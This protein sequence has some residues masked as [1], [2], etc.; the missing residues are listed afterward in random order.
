MFPILGIVFVTFLVI[1]VAIPVLPLHVHDGLGLGPFIV[2]LVAGSQFAASL[3]S[4]IWAGRQAD[5]R[6]P[7]YAVL[8]GL[9][10]S[11]IAGVIYLVS[12]RFA[13]APALSAAIL[14]V[15]RGVL[16]AGESL[17]ITG[18]Q[19]WGLAIAPAGTTGR[20]IAWVG[21]AMFAAFALGA[22][23]GSAIYSQFGF[24]SIAWATVLM[25]LATVFLAM[26]MGRI[27]PHAHVEQPP[28]RRVIGFVL[29]PGIGLALASIGFGAI[30]AF[31]SLLFSARGWPVWLAFSAYAIAFVLAR[32]ALGHLADRVGGARVAIAF[33]LVEAI[34][35]ALM[36]GAQWLPMALLGAALTGLGFS[37][38]YPALGIEA[39]RRTPAQSRGTAMGVYGAFLDLALGFAGPVL[40]LVASAAG[41]SVVFIASAVAV[42]GGLFFAV[43]LL[44]VRAAATLEAS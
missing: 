2:G 24:A 37:L 27:A 40:G 35:L 15:G 42:C 29:V 8:A 9:A 41:I 31:A 28:V 36:W 21:T 43:R 20:V 38:V 19:A 22:P 34:G 26:R 16:G 7:R 14:I 5:V 44:P 23:A 33:M 10:A 39:V 17:V 12:L 1:G 32:I 11:A 4:R 25:P 3:L 30:S 13:D 6:G 18:A